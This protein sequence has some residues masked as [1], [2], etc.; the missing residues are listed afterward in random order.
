L[1][2]QPNSKAKTKQQKSINPNQNFKVFCDSFHDK[3]YG[4]S[5]NLISLAARP[6]CI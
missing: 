2:P 5:Q 1:N 3:L 4:F 6:D